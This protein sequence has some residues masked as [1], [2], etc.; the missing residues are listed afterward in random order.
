MAKY[1]LVTEKGEETKKED[2][3]EPSISIDLYMLNI[4]LVTK[5]NADTNSAVMPQ[6]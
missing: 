1:Q 2:I 5:L 3:K 6:P 4:L